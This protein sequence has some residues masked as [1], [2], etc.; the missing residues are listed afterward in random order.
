MEA[1]ED[2]HAYQ[3]A[4]QDLVPVVGADVIFVNGWDLEETLIQDLEE[5]GKGVPV[6]AISANIEP[7]IFGQDEDGD[8]EEEHEHQH[9]A[10]PHTWFAIQN[11]K[12]WV[13]NTESVLSELDPNNAGTYQDNAAAYL[14]ELEE[15]ET[16][17]EAELA[18]IKEADRVLVTNHDSLG[19]FAEAYG[20]T[21]LDTVLPTAST[22]AEP[23]ASDLAGLIEQMRE[24]G[25]C[26]IVTETTAGGSLAQT[27]TDELDDCEEV[28]IVELYTGS[29]GPAGSGADSYTG[30]FRA[31]VEAIVEVLQ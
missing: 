22:L 2:P 9:G 29:I 31:N 18:Q 14:V 27:V 5:I 23:S 1:G 8:G 24:H 12:Q 25:V 17:A 16:F 19:Y 13:E 20:F 6:V 28:D 10:D 26:V 3:P 21:V 4:A 30:M 15:L 11:V 7:L